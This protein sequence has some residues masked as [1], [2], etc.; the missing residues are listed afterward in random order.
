MKD[1]GIEEYFEAAKTIH[2]KYPEISF[3]LVGEYEE[4]TRE[5]YEPVIKNLENQGILKYYGHI[6]NVPEVMAQSHIIVHPS[7][8]EGLSNVCLEAAACGRPVLTTDVPGCRETVV[9]GERGSGTLFS[10]KSSESLIGALEAV[11]KL[12][13]KQREEMGIVG[14]EHVEKNFN[15]QLVI[16]AY[17]EAIEGDC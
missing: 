6:D 10:A 14:R 13:L 15:R 7:Y 17:H 12:S 5:K 9:A 3:E 4:E 16:N 8:H 1:K 11:L 2:Q